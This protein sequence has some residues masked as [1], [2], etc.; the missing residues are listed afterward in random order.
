MRADIEAGR[1]FVRLYMKNGEFIAGMK[2]AKRLLAEMGVTMRAVGRDLFMGGAAF[3]LT[4]ALSLKKYADFD[5]ALREVKATTKATEQQLAGLSDQA[6]ELAQRFGFSAVEVANVMAELGR[7]GFEVDQLNQASKAVMTLA[8][9][10]KTDALMSSIVVG[11]TMKQFKMAASEATLIADMLTVAANKSLI[12]IEHI[13]DSLHYAGP[14]AQEFNVGLSETL[15][16]IAALGNLGIRGESA[17]TSLRRLLTISGAEARRMSEVFGVSFTDSQGKI[18]PLID[19]LE[20]VYDLLSK[21]DIDVRARKFHEAFGIIGL[22]GAEA[23]SSNV[24]NIRELRA[25]I[26]RAGGEAAKQAATMNSGF[27]GFLRKLSASVENLTLTLGVLFDKELRS[28][29]KLITDLVDGF[30]A[31]AGSNKEFALNVVKTILGVT[32]L[33][34]A[35][36][37]AGIAIRVIGFSIAGISSVLNVLR[38]TVMGAVSALLALPPMASWVASGVRTAFLS[39]RE[40]YSYFLQGI[41]GT[42][43]ATISG[44]FNLRSYGLGGQ[45]LQLGIAVRGAL[46]PLGQLFRILAPG[47]SHLYYFAKALMGTTMRHGLLRTQLT[48]MEQRFWLWGA[49]V[50]YIFRTVVAS[51][52]RGSIQFAHAMRFFWM[53]IQ[54]RNVSVSVFAAMSQMQR[55]VMAMGSYVR[56]YFIAP[57][58]NLIASTGI[59][60]FFAFIRR[61]LVAMSVNAR[62]FWN[63]LVGRSMTPMLFRSLTAVQLAFVTMGAR[64]NYFFRPLTVAL[65]NAFIAMV[66][67]ARQSFYVIRQIGM[68]AGLAVG[69]VWSFVGSGIR[70]GLG[71][72]VQG[73]LGLAMVASIFLG[74]GQIGG[75]LGTILQVVPMLV[76]L[77]PSLA[78]LVNPW[79]LLVIAIASGIYYWARF[80]EAGIMTVNRLMVILKPL[81]EIGSKMVEGISAAFMSG[82]LELAV[83]IAV[84]GIKSA[85]YEGMAGVFR[86]IYDLWNITLGEM[87]TLA[88][89]RLKGSWWLNILGYQADLINAGGTS[90]RAAGSQADAL[91]VKEYDATVKTLFLLKEQLEA[92]QK[93][94]DKRSVDTLTNEIRSY[95]KKL[96][97]VSQ[98]MLPQGKDLAETWRI[99]S[100]KTR[101]ELDKLVEEAKKRHEEFL[102]ARAIK[103]AEEEKKIMEDRQKVLGGRGGLSVAGPTS[104]TF[105]A[106]EAMMNNTNYT[107]GRIVEILERIFK[108]EEKALFKWDEYIKE[109]K[110]LKR[111]FQDYIHSTAFGG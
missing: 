74:G 57:F 18:R 40:A 13:G 111:V 102:K 14:V 9:A 98:V 19:S 30:S 92:A 27:G 38:G 89:A 87:M 110:D 33:G 105:S 73:F 16:I 20:D 43:L 69:K 59:G 106:Q 78:A 25:A 79:S 72:T 77:G 15:A 21:E 95:L 24:V 3:S 68:M 31:F 94:G 1:A 22:T 32:A 70:T 42:R 65:Q 107:Q 100:D 7:G 83:Q 96:D 84:V 29:A 39:M 53:A 108:A 58:I 46:G 11:S 99:K 48:A 88:A 52:T 36:F 41:S 2:Q 90:A 51:A 35:L 86:D 104:A 49:R 4:A 54:G 34:A 56:Y 101:A 44:A 61:S 80:T 93:A 12:T 109:G 55:R 8:R 6:R 47:S 71:K 60:T 67:V 37:V 26:N 64:M 66:P 17:G 28:G 45:L 23:I 81:T 82:E 5:D 97:Q 75:A 50:N 103:E 85:F 76:L 91:K 10:T 63:A 62:L